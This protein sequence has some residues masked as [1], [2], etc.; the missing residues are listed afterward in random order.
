MTPN[1]RL[2]LKSGP[3]SGQTLD[4]GTEDVFIGRDVNST[5]VVSDPEVSRRHARLYRQ[6]ENYLIEDLGSTNGTMVSGQRLT[7][8]YILR[9][10]E[11]IT[12]GEHTVILFEK[13]QPDPDATVASLRSI[14]TVLETP[15][16]VAEPIKAEPVVTPTPVPPVSPGPG[17]VYVGNVPAQPRPVRA[18]GKRQISTLT[19]VL[20][21]VVIILALGC[22]GFAIF[23]ALNLYCEFPGITN[24]FIPGACPP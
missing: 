10:G 15:A 20:I 22:I 1:F 23:D 21:V 3:N 11:I 17:E 5:F 4:L 7:G 6:G 24:F 18:A 13:V 16:P 14:E 12:L 2:V 8:P 9:P 19:I